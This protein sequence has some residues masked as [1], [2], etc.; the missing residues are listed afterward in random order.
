MPESHINVGVGRVV[1]PI[2]DSISNHKS[3]EVWLE[4]G[5]VISVLGVILIDIVGEVRHVNSGVRLTR[6]VELV[7]LELEEL[8]EP[9]EDGI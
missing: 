3:L 6:D 8:L 2:R 5:R 7:G 9:S 4:D 1:L